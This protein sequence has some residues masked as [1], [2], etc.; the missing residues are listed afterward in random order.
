MARNVLICAEENVLIYETSLTDEE[1]TAWAKLTNTIPH[2]I[3]TVTQDDLQYYCIDGRIW[4]N[5]AKDA[6]VR[7]ILSI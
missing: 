5:E 1:L 7:H 6:N 4:M 3:I 2:D